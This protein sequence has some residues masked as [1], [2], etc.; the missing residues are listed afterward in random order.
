MLSDSSKE[1]QHWHDKYNELDQ[2]FKV[3][4]DKSDSYIK[5]KEGELEDIKKEVK[6][7]S[8]KY[9][10]HEEIFRQEKDRADRYQKLYTE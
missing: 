8:Y 2:K 10:N 7:M 4:F 1:V 6:D 5:Q 3:Y 9:A